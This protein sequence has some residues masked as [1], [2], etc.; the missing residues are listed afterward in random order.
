[1]SEACAARKEEG[2]SWRQL[3]DRG[4]GGGVAREGYMAESEKQAGFFRSLSVVERETMASFERGSIEAPVAKI[5]DGKYVEES[6][7]GLQ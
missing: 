2:G 7:K 5:S 6:E 1:M 4:F 3:A